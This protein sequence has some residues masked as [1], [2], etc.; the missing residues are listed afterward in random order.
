MLVE[1][2]V[3]FFNLEIKYMDVIQIFFPS[4]KK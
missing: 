2:I 3:N 1:F 4:R